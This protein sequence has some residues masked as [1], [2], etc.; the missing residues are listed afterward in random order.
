MKFACS[1][2]HVI[3][4]GTDYL[5]YKAYLISDQDI[6]DA[7]EMSDR[8]SGDWWPTLTRTMYDCEKCGRVWIYDHAG[9]LQS[10]LPESRSPHFLSSIAGIKWKRILR[11]SWTD[12]PILRTLPRG[13]LSWTHLDDADRRT[14][15]EW[16]E[17]ESEYFKVFESLRSE[18][19]LRD[20]LLKRNGE[21]IHAWP[22]AE[23]NAA[24]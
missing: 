3:S 5:R 8:G 14:F 11:G 10:F 18:D 21:V 22:E 19:L 9:L 6:Y 2:G 23:K 16:A 24:K 20:S 15:E 17:L 1:C 13:F 4:D 7:L 12:K